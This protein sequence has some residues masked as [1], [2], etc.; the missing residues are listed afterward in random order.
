VAPES[1]AAYVH[2]LVATGGQTGEESVKGGTEPP[3][4][5]VSP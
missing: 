5:F 3:P 4:Y 1:K 2:V